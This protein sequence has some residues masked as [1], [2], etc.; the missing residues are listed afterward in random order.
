MSERMNTLHCPYSLCRENKDSEVCSL[1]M[2]LCIALAVIFNVVIFNAVIFN[3]VLH[4]CT[5]LLVCSAHCAHCAVHT[6]HN[7]HNVHSVR[8]VTREVKGQDT[9]HRWRK[10]RWGEDW[11]F[12]TRSLPKVKLLE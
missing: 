10:R 9:T 5:L 4:S 2:K 7:V 12:F 11:K 1:D 8:C 3:A 6:L